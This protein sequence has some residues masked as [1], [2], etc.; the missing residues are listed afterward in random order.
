M[1]QSVML[2]A[3]RQDDE[4]RQALADVAKWLKKRSIAPVDV[5]G[6]EGQIGQ[7]QLRSVVAGVSFGGDGTFLSMVDRLSKKDQ[8]PLMGVNLGTLG[9]ITSVGRSEVRPELTKVLEGSFQE[10]KRSLFSASILRKQK[11]VHSGVFVNDA[12]VVKDASAPLLRFE[13]RIDGS[14]LTRVRAD[15]FIISSATGST[16]Y[17]LSAGGPLVHPGTDVILLIPICA[18]SLSSRP[19]VVPSTTKA[20]LV[21]VEGKK[22]ATL[23]FDGQRKFSLDAGD[24]V[25]TNPSKSTLRLIGGASRQWSE[26]L[27][28]KLKMA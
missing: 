17:A 28:N 11:S 13:L 12:V 19:I 10:E 23:V 18:H 8:F 20:E 6:G 2:M 24:I 1:K 21:L 14:L 22:G 7:S 27:R 26:A 4:A 9:F 5:T 25:T 15:G 16:A 3:K